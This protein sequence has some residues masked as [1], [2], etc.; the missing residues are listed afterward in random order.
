MG[1]SHEEMPGS[2][3]IQK[4]KRENKQGWIE[5]QKWVNSAPIDYWKEWSEQKG[6]TYFLNNLFSK[7]LI[8]HAFFEVTVI[9]LLL[10][11]HFFMKVYWV[12]AEY[13]RSKER[14]FQMSS[15]SAAN[16][17]DW[18]VRR[19]GQQYE[20]QGQMGIGQG[21]PARDTQ[22]VTHAQAK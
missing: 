21:P 2:Y 13:K 16:V 17:F 20:K 8:S 14:Q 6:K 22:P 12:C 11:F 9:L 15:D 7:T 3:F 19:S 18:H 10:W 1:Q 5:K 4:G